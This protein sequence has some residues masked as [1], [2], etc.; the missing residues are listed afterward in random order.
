MR[1]ILASLEVVRPRCAAG[2]PPR[3]RLRLHRSRHGPERGQTTRKRPRIHSLRG[4]P[5]QIRSFVLAALRALHLDPSCGPPNQAR[6][7]TRPNN[8]RIPPLRGSPTQ[9]RNPSWT[10]PATRHPPAR[11][12]PVG[13]GT[14][15]VTASGQLISSSPVSHSAG[16]WLRLKLVADLHS[17]WVLPCELA[18][19]RYARSTAAGGR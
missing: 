3:P 10:P 18:G 5:T 2:A 13:G 4:S 6:T 12:V 19:S 9:I 1:R 14:L 17:S 7:G 16:G 15:S 8:Q 11:H